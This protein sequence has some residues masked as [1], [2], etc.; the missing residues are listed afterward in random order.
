MSGFRLPSCGLID[1][2]RPLHFTFDGKRYQ[3]FAGDSLASA[4]LANGVDILGRSFKY[5][6]PRGLFSAGVEEPN[7]MV[8][9]RSSART[10]PNCKAPMVELFEGLE[11]KSQNRWPSLGLD[12]MALNGLAGPLLS[13]GFYYKTFMG[14]TR[15]AWMFYEHFIRKAAGMGA[16]TQLRDPDRYEETNAFCDVLIAGAGPTGLMAAL[17]A[18]QSGA[19]IVLVDDQAEMGGSLRGT[20]LTVGEAAGDIWCRSALAVLSALPNVTLLPRTTVYGYYDDNTFGAVERVSDHLPVPPEA[21]PR[22]RHWTIRAKQLVIAAGAIERPLIFAG[23]DTPGV[24]LADAIRIYVERYG[25]SPGQRIALFANN[26]GAYRTVAALAKAGVTVVAVVDPRPEI[27]AEA[28][29]V[30]EGCGAELLTGHVVTRARGGRRLAAIEVTPYDPAN[31]VQDRLHRSIPVDCL[32]VSGGWTP[33][34]HLASQAS[35]PAR[36]DEALAAFL[37]GEPTQPWQA[38]GACSGEL[39]TAACLTAGIQ[40]GAEA[41]RAC[42]FA[43]SPISV[44]AVGPEI[45]CDAILPLWDARPAGGKGKAFVDLQ[46][47][48][49]ASDVS[50]AH[51]EGFRSVEHLKRYTT[52]GMATD[53]GKTSNMAGLAL[54][55]QERG[56]SIPEVGTTR[57]RP[58]YTPIALGALAGQA[59]GAH[60][61]PL[62]RTP[63]HDWH[64]AEGAD[65]MEVGLWQR[66]RVYRRDGETVEQ[67]YIREARQVRQSVGIVDV[68][69]LGK[70]D[71]QGPDAAEFLNRV[72][73]NGF[74]KLPEGKARYGLMLRED[75]FL[76]DDGTTWRLGEHRFLMTTT[77]ANAAPVLAQLEFLLAA[78]WPEMKVAVTSVSDQWA[79]MAVSGPKARDLLAAVLD[80]IGMS[81]EAFPFMGVREGHLDGVP[82]LVARLSFSG[83]LAY[84]VYAGAHSGE[85]V[86]RRIMAAGEAFDVVA[87]GLEALGTLRIEKGHVAGPE[88]DGRTTA[89]DLGLGGMTS[90]RKDYIGSA[91]MDREGLVDDNR[92]KLVGLISR[93]GQ[94]VRSGSHLIVPNG[95]SPPRSLG[96]VTS[97]TYS[98]ALE[99]YIALGLLEDGRNRIGEALVATYPLKGHNVD[100][101]VVSSHFFDPEG[102]RMHV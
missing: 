39:S 96:H 21:T 46:H 33:T 55:A 23:N 97:S 70:I 67:A 44:P 56:L 5:H 66:P 11:A 45:T 99:K 93:D 4:L 40:A 69:T 102:S 13:A 30:V 94:P 85:A 43:P 2:S 20:S 88:L 47:D 36:W 64:V 58:P 15:K 19:R 14:P 101:E 22:Q 49:T 38:A 90:R 82:V 81:N 74:L 35:G 9:L 25:V 57:F 91:M 83:E 77:T 72:Y 42:G 95:E 18:A 73:S 80:D 31:G 98:P 26:D 63:M 34:I 61:R 10:E 92:M 41:A 75:G 12:I 28:R 76:W 60:F 16:G 100:V 27:G 89:E 68:S 59:R 79:A 54:M 86:W 87:Y 7:A 48:V 71:V 3:G 65:M 6:R 84:E 17:A 8:T 53:Q 52:L 78:V 32:A 50:L 51:R 24:M 62:R 1:R 29:S 37:P